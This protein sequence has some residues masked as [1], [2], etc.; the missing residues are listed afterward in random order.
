MIYLICPGRERGVVTSTERSGSPRIPPPK[1]WGLSPDLLTPTRSPMDAEGRS[2]PSITRPNTP[3][4]QYLFA[5]FPIRLPTQSLSRANR[6]ICLM[7]PIS[8]R[9]AKPTKPCHEQTTRYCCCCCCCCCCYTR[10]LRLPRG[11]AF[12]NLSRIEVPRLGSIVHRSSTDRRQIIHRLSTDYLCIILAA[13]SGYLQA[14][15]SIPDLV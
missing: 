15:R 11:H 1:P 4:N 6:A 8:N 5:D 10:R 9:T 14:D 3:N 12:Q 13:I 2:R 7:L